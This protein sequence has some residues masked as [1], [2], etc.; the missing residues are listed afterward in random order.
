MS[1]INSPD[2]YDSSYRGSR[3]VRVDNWALVQV[4]EQDGTEYSRQAARFAKAASEVLF[5][6]RVFRKDIVTT[7]IWTEEDRPFVLWEHFFIP[8]DQRQP[9]STWIDWLVWNPRESHRGFLYAKQ[10]IS[11]RRTQIKAERR[12]EM[13]ASRRE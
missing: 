4:L 2:H 7:H 10:L 1:I 13:A 3:L 11:N 6:K 12:A 5:F 8:A 9:G